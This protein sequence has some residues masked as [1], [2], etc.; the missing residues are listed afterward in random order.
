VSILYRIAK[1]EGIAL[2]LWDGIVTADEYLASVQR[3]ID[4]TNWPPHRHL[5]LG[6]L[7]T[8]LLDPS[9]DESALRRVAAIY[10]QHL[11]ILAKTKSAIVAN[12]AF[13]RSLFFQQL[14]TSS[15]S[16]VVF[17]DLSTACRWLGVETDWAGC[18]L[19]EMRAE[20]RSRQ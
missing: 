14:M 2:D 9:L 20:L 1:D 8:A 15:V 4:D 10:G 11:D 3:L 16:M 19:S 12:E 18:V 13:A 5:H 6:D 17:N 7:Q